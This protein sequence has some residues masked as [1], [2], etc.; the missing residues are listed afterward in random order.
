MIPGFL[1]AAAS[2]FSLFSASSSMSKMRLAAAPTSA[3]AFAATW[4]SK[5]FF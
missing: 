1:M 4:I 3:S 5:I 2:R